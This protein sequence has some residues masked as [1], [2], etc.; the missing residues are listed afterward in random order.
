MESFAEDDL[1]VGCEGNA[2][3]KKRK[4]QEIITTPEHQSLVG[5]TLPRSEIESSAED[6][7]AAGL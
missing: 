7:L 3:H 6:G 5:S 1:Q 4:I 2:A